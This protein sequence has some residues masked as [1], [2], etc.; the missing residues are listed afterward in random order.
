MSIEPVSRS[1]KACD[2]RITFVLDV[3]K[4]SRT[5]IV[6]HPT[7]RFEPQECYSTSQPKR[8]G[9]VCGRVEKSRPARVIV[10]SNVRFWDISCSPFGSRP[11]DSGERHRRKQLAFCAT[12]FLLTRMAASMLFALAD[13][14]SH[15]PRSRRT[16]R[17]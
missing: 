17:R 7:T 1:A 9:Q 12:L 8:P 3:S 14:F 5:N 13:R 6:A 2:K 16:H 4:P 10:N 11:R 15:R